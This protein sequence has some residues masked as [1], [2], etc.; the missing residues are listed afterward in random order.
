MHICKQN[1]Y[2]LLAKRRPVRYNKGMFKVLRMIC[3]IL[4]A[5][6]VAGAIFIFVY[7]GWV[8]G[9]V[10]ICAAALLFGLCVLFKNL[11]TKQEEKQNPPPAVGDFITGA[12]NVN[13][14]DKIDEKTE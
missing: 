1:K 11:Q 2:N 7:L 6:I 9:V 12:V 10:A 13:N 14:D 4:S 8:W 5:V 3:G